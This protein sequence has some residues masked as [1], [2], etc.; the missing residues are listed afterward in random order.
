[1]YNYADK[2]GIARMNMGFADN[3]EK[4]RKKS[5]SNRLLNDKRRF[6]KFITVSNKANACKNII[7]PKPKN[8]FID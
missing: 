2:N 1:M 5:C 6:N 4:W 8:K 3:I 7:Y